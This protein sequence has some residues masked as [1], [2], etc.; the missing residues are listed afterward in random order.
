M[1]DFEQT[2]IGYRNFTYNEKQLP[3]G[4]SHDIGN[5]LCWYINEYVPGKNM[6]NFEFYSTYAVDISFLLP[7]AIGKHIVTCGGRNTS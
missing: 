2:Q 5:E 6:T 4:A 3:P 1:I 7:L